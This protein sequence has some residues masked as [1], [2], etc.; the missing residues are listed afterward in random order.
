MAIFTTAG[1]KVYI[2]GVLAPNFGSPVTTTTFTAQTWAAI[3][4]LE[5]IGSLGDTS[6]EVTFNAIADARIHKLKGSR[7]AGT[8]EMV[9]GIDYGNAG[10]IAVLAAEA[11]PSSY[12]F[13]IVFND[14][15]PSGTPSER[16]FIGM[17]M[18]AA[19]QLDGADNVMKL[20]IRVGINSNIV[21]IAADS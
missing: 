5:N 19:E 13:R 9:A 12:A 16:L 15:P 1:A 14:A 17:V 8:L 2:G 21:R 18:S 3:E 6:N 11:S 4:P 20:N 7:D 10:Q